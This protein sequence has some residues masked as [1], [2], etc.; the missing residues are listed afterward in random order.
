MAFVPGF[1]HDIFISYAHT[2]NPGGEENGRVTRLH[3]LLVERL[4][5]LTDGQLNIWRDTGLARNE[6][7]DET[8]KRRIESSA[9]FLAINST[10]YQKSKY[11]QQEIEWF[12]RRSREDGYGLGVSSLHRILNVLLSDIPH[13]QWP[14]AFQGATKFDFFIKVE[15]DP[16]ALPAEPDSPQ[17]KKEFDVLLRNLARTLQE[18]KKVAEIKQQQ[19]TATPPANP[20]QFTVFLADM[21]EDLRR[22]IRKRL[23]AEFP[24]NG[25]NL[26]DAVPPP[27]EAASHD[28]KTIQ[29]IERAHLSLHLFDGSPGRDIED[30]SDQFYTHRQVELGK[31]HARQ[32]WIWLPNEIKYDAINYAPHRNF[33]RD[34]ENAERDAASY[35][36]IRQPLTPDSVVREVVAYRDR[37]LAE[38]AAQRQP[39]T[40][41]LDAHFQDLS[42]AL[43]SL[44]PRLELRQVDLEINYGEDE[45]RKNI[46]KLVQKL[47][48]TSRLLM[49]FG[50]W[51]RKQF[52]FRL[53]EALKICFEEDVKLQACGIYFA[54]PHSLRDEPRFDFGGFV[55]LHQFD[56]ANLDEGLAHWLHDRQS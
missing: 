5:E 6:L 41:L 23:L 40:A 31:Q 22:T 52:D 35:R 9:L 4:R 20:E 55:R 3:A 50:H 51:P 43:A 8:L 33:L 39:L 53:R 36:F 1:E 46:E 19:A 25:L 15:G 12:D 2:N 16:I 18:F 26:T 30:L 34:L 7:F 28:A 24:Q 44:K 13:T 54:N 27:M 42:G 38:L 47:K 45:P 10:A 32:Q 56:N 21:S 11:C 14:A 49:V 29:E 37:Y 17:F 48:S